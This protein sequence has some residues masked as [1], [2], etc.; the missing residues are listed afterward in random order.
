MLVGKPQ[1]RKE[2]GKELRGLLSGLKRASPTGVEPKPKEA[3]ER[4][5]C[6]GWLFSTRKV[7]PQAQNE[8]LGF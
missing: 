8:T 4:V 2:I 5:D 7:E 6:R 1:T 3:D